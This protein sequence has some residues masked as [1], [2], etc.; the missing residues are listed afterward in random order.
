M[1][2]I[3]QRCDQKTWEGTGAH[4][5]WRFHSIFFPFYYQKINLGWWDLKCWPSLTY[6]T[7]LC[8]PWSCAPEGGQGG[9][10]LLSWERIMMHPE[11]KRG[12]WKTKPHSC[13]EGRRAVL[14]PLPMTPCWM[15]LG[16]E[17]W[18][19]VECRPMWGRCFYLKNLSSCPTQ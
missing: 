9:R 4:K 3:A 14:R 19:V 5:S 17:G 13:T 1:S 18:A 12:Q 11:G 8:L 15:H 2:S 6:Y 16:H 10:R 7:S